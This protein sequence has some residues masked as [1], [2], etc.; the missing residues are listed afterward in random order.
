M[1]KAKKIVSIS[2]C[3]FIAVTFIFIA[4]INIR[5]NCNGY[6]VPPGFTNS[7]ITADSGRSPLTYARI[8]SANLLANYAS[9]GGSDAHSRAKMFFGVLDKYRPDVVAVQE[10]SNQWYCCIAKNNG[11]YNLVYPIS[12]GILYHMTGLMYNSK[13]VDLLDFGRREFTRG[14]DA[15]MR[16]VVW[17]LFEDK[18]TKTRYVVTS[19][20]FD[21]IR[22]GIEKKE[23]SVMQTQ[24][25]EQIAIAQKLY[26]KFDC[27]VFAAGDF[28]AMDNGAYGNKYYAPGVYETL[29]A[30][31]TDTKYTACF[32]TQGDSRSV[33]KPTFDHIFYKGSATVNRYAILSDNVMN[34]MSDHFVIFADIGK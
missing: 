23:L 13:T 2:L 4:V 7:M 10:M 15:R 31:L 27:P 22:D 26:E 30:H 20:H 11:D 34:K 19:C 33:N 5:G 25:I 3:F 8:M 6:T 32:K 21:L 29:A 17:G 12:S 9:W 18:K 14:D 16:R 24:A 28:N 1:K